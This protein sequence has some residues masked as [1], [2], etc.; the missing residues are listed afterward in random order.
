MRGFVLK[1]LLN[2]LSKHTEYS[3]LRGIDPLESVLQGVLPRSRWKFSLDLGRAD[4]TFGPKWLYL[5]IWILEQLV[6]V[7]ENYLRSVYDYYSTGALLTPDGLVSGAHG[8][9]SGV[10]FTNM[11]E[12]F[13]FRIMARL[14][15]RRIGVN[16]RHIFQNGDDGLYL[17]DEECKAT[18]MA[19]VYQ[20]YGF[21]L[22]ADKSGSDE[23]KCS[24]LQR[25]F[26]SD[27]EYKAVM[28]TNRMLGRILYAERS[29]IARTGLAV[30]DYWT[31]NTI[32]KLENCK[33]HPDFYSLVDFVRAGDEFGLDPSN[34]LGVDPAAAEGYSP[35]GEGSQ[36]GSGFA[37]FDTVR[38]PRGVNLQRGGPS[39]DRKRAR[40]INRV[41]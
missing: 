15:G 27:H 23:S 8:L 16:F 19:A 4:S 36:G 33:R 28:S 39:Y 38:Y 18:D 1:P 10:A 22:N 21:V 13:V 35:F 24:Y 14:A 34:I 11:F 9:P 7:D 26:Y 2:E 17:S 6:Y 32:M 40:N 20:D 3:H 25:H 5:A 29:S 12:V 37:D 31:A 30:K 41:S